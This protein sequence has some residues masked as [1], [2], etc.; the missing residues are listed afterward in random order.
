MPAITQKDKRMQILEE[1]N[2]QLTQTL[3]EL[4]KQLNVSHSAPGVS[5][6]SSNATRKLQDEINTLTKRNC[7]KCIYFFLY[8]TL[9]SSILF[10][11]IFLHFQN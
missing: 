7:G 2:A 6:D 1:E 8:A 11:S 9:F 5:P 10:H 4:K 3:E